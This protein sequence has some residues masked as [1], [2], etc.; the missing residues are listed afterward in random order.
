M[1]FAKFIKNDSRVF[2]LLGINLRLGLL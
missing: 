1:A 2:K